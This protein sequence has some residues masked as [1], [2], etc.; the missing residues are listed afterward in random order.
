MNRGC[1]GSLIT[2]LCQ[3]TAGVGSVVLNGIRELALLQVS[4][5][6]AGLLV[7]SIKHVKSMQE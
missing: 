5:G 4:P 1:A 7:K 6:G 3:L 2:S